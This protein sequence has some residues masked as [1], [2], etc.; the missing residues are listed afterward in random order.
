MREKEAF[1]GDHLL[2]LFMGQLKV[3]RGLARN[4]VEAYNRDLMGFFSFLRQRNLSPTKVTQDD[5]VSFIA[6]KRTRLSSRSLARCL[7]SLRM[8]YRFL[9]SEGTMSVNPAR[10]LGIPK[11]YQH[12]PHVLNRDEVEVLLAQPDRNTPMGRRDKAMLELLYATGLRASEL[13]GLSMANVN[14]EAGY[15]RTMG[16]GSKE[17]IVPMGSEAVDSLKRYIIDGRASLLKKGTSSY[18]FLNS[19]GGR[20]TRQGLWKILKNYARKAGITKRITPH[21]LRHSF[22]THLLEGGADL[23]SVQVMLGHSDISTTQIY[24]HVA[25][26]RL[27][28]VHEKYHPRP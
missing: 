7:V 21:T 23:R 17:R 19:R 2:D 10:L 24:T 15:L 26:E 14:L 16:K 5:L 22:A 8:F 1:Q 9:V 20:L 4:T 27:K 11:L 13:I 6:E 3:E 18:L 25:R 12:L 28:E